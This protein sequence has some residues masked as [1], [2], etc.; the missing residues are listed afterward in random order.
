MSVSSP[1]RDALVQNGWALATQLNATRDPDWP[2]CV[3]CAMLARSFDRTRSP[4]PGKCRQCFDRYCWDGRID[5]AAPQP[6][7]PKFVGTAIKV[8]GAAASRAAHTSAKTA[9]LI[10]TGAALGL[11]L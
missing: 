7:R 1:E 5:E 6:Y 3:G 10:V 4:V 11:L 2:V 9:V 8:E